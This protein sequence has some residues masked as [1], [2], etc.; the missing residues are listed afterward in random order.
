MLKAFS[1]YTNEIDDAEQAVAEILEQISSQELLANSVG[2][3]SCYAD[4]ID[5]GAL[6][7]VCDALPFEV[8]G[9]TTLSSVV[10]GSEDI[11]QLTLLV[12]SSDDISFAIGL[13]DPLPEP[14]MA[15]LK[16]AYAD[17][18]AKLAGAPSLMLSFA[19][20][21]LNAGGDFF[22][23]ALNEIAPN[24]PSFGPLAVDHNADYH[25][26]QVIC[27]GEGYSN[28]FAFI[29]LQGN[30]SPRFFVAGISSERVFQEKGVVTAAQEN[31]L[32]TVN[33]MPVGDYL[34]TLGL[35][36]NADGTIT[37]INSYP[38]IV[39]YNDGTTPVVR[40]MFA[41][42]P[43]GYAVCG[44]NIPV[45][46]TLS[47][48]SIDANE[49][50]STTSNTLLEVL[51]GEKPRCLIMYSCVG[52]LFAQGYDTQREQNSVK[53]ALAQT[54]IPYQFAY[55]GGELCPVYATQD[56]TGQTINRNHNE[57]YIVCAL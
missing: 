44:G 55:A 45:G 43:E 15:P 23:E 24:V 8:A 30:V 34:L 49:I 36:K 52:R 46:A 6:K 38:F 27:N 53:A 56:M 50:V 32:Q 13:S 33:N 35:Q 10:A 1:A 47:V 40:V 19:P 20:L 57:T 28:R 51:A 29:L 16:R 25:N 3:V 31:Q 7:A 2:I 41:L 4:F 17:T 11:M 22:V 42:T 48:G 26:A 18:V 9:I 39:D 14:D 21:L 5:S 37:G 12:L 54:D